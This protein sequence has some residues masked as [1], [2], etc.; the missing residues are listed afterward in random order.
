MKYLI[1][2]GHFYQPPREDPWTGLVD[3]QPSALPYHDWNER[4]TRE[5]YAANTASRVLGSEGRIEDIINNYRFISFNFGPTLMSWLKNNSPNIYKKIISADKESRTRNLG[6]GNALA[7]VYNHMILPLAVQ[8]DIKTQ[9]LWGKADFVS[10]FGRDPEGMW[11]SETAISEPV[12][13]ELIRQKIRYVVLSPWQAEAILDTKTGSWTELNDKPAPCDRAFLIK[14]KEGTL[15]VFFY[16]PDLAAGIS[17]NHFLHNADDLLYRIKEIFKDT[18]HGCLVNVATDGEIYGHH[19]PFGD[20]CL[21]ALI[22]KIEKDPWLT[23]TNYSHFLDLFPAE[24]EVRLRKGE[25]GLGT[26]WS[27]FH[28]VSRW[29]KDC[30]CNTGS[31]PGWNQQWRTPLR[32][33]L[34]LLRRELWSTFTRETAKLSSLTPE[35]IRNRF[36]EVLTGKTDRDTFAAA[37]LSKN[38]SD[39]RSRLSRLLEGQKYAQFMFTS[40]GWFFSELSGIEPVQNLKYAAKA[41]D[42]YRPLLPYEVE[43]PFINLLRQAES[44]IKEQG[45]GA[46]VFTRYAIPDPRLHH[47]MGGM[48]LTLNG[49]EMPLKNFGTFCNRGITFFSSDGETEGVPERRGEVTL[50]DI[51][52]QEESII[53]FEIEEPDESL[54]PRIRLFEGERPFLFQMEHIPLRIRE[55]L[56]DHRH[57]LLKKSGLDMLLKMVQSGSD[58]SK[59]ASLTSALPRCAMTETAALF[60]HFSV[61]GTLLR[62]METRETAE[63]IPL[64]EGLEEKL[65]VLM[66]YGWGCQKETMD[67]ASRNIVYQLLEKFIAHPE[68]ELF[69]QL[70]KLIKLFHDNG[71]DPI[72]P[73][74]QDIVFDELVEKKGS[75]GR[76][77]LLELSEYL[78]FNT[79]IFSRPS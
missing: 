66:K 27:C 28:G 63:I 9:I 13:D 69:Q 34:N 79:A 18:E 65:P 33:S 14:R 77:E 29:Y 1:I 58:T 8:E 75:K 35:V 31:A 4:I 37:V 23:V 72:K 25:E 6:H 41:L 20:M 68:N 48:F 32:E 51:E 38:T 76:K 24:E 2:H 61:T 62:M 43:K 36:I 16:H 15:S 44:N 64:M 47:K 46:A 42:I 59:L 7:Q 45:N 40:C 22:K 57:H 50:F 53:R 12:I 78:N 17:F 30:G 10:H 67:N 54:F 11:L 26:S 71:L 60:L 74:L 39:N 73:Q 55:R 49:L 5:C 19:E 56:A 70:K 3:H 21:A 52:L